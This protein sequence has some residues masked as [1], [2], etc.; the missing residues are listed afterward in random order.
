MNIEKI[1]WIANDDRYKLDQIEIDCRR[2]RKRMFVSFLNMECGYTIAFHR[3]YKEEDRLQFADDA[4]NVLDIL[5]KAS[6]K[7]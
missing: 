4:A 2:L 3:N 1:K 5:N 6:K 7:E